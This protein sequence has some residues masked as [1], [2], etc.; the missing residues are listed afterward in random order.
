MT[1][2]RVSQARGP[3]GPL[4]PEQLPR[5]VELSGDQRGRTS[6]AAARRRAM[7]SAW[8]SGGD[9]P[10][11]NALIPVSSRPMVS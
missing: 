7:A 11:Q 3:P 10:H 9:N 8:L 4:A 1:G 5:S 6:A 2:S